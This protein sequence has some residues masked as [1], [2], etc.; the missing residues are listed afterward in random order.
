M[1][2][3][4]TIK[5][6]KDTIESNNLM[7]PLKMMV[8]AKFA[9]LKKNLPADKKAKLEAIDFREL[10]EIFVTMFGL[11]KHMAAAYELLKNQQQQ[12]QQSKEGNKQQESKNENNKKNDDDDDDE[13]DDDEEI[14]AEEA[15]K[16]NAKEDL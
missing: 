14:H 13:D 5:L 8:G 15:N 2:F 7:G 12:Q 16:P 6:V 4:K 10:S 3:I 11:E 1:N 9:D